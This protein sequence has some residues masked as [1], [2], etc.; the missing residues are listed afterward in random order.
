MNEQQRA[1]YPDDA[2][3]EALQRVA[4]QGSD[5]S[6]PMTIEFVIST[7]EMSMARSVAQ[8]AA[9]HGYQT[10]IHL[11]DEGGS[12]DVSCAKRMVA[13]YESVVAGQAE[14]TRLCE[15]LGLVCESWATYGNEG[16][17]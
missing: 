14:L 16:E 17:Q 3:G 9:D 1:S 5:M 2:D 13:T 6:R 15:P 8:L 4:D 11:D 10:D 7:R 12:I